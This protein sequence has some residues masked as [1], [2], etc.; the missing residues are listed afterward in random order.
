MRFFGFLRHRGPPF[1]LGIEGLDILGLAP[2]GLLSVSAQRTSFR[3]RRGG[4]PFWLSTQVELQKYI[5]CRVCFLVNRGLP[6]F[7]GSKKTCLLPLPDAR[8][9]GGATARPVPPVAYFV[10]Q[11]Q[12]VGI[13]QPVW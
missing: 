6:N 3:T 5:E 11:P 12:S 8:A 2:E 7:R 13:F 9:P 10:F 4:P 1:S